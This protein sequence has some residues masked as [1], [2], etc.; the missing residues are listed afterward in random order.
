M[1][2]EKK[3]AIKPLAH[4]Q[5]EDADEDSGDVSRPFD[6]AVGDLVQEHVKAAIAEDISK[7]DPLQMMSYL[8]REVDLH[9]IEMPQARQQLAAW[10]NALP[11]K[12]LAKGEG[13]IRMRRLKQIMDATF[14]EFHNITSQV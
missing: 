3:R 8:V 7:T 9:H 14:E 10:F 5:P 11:D 4:S 12:Q 13:R 1:A 2:D 6:Q